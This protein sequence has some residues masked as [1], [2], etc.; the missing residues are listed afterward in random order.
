MDCVAVDSA[1]NVTVTGVDMNRDGTHECVST[2]PVDEPATMSST[3]PLTGNTIVATTAVVTT[4]FA[5]ADCTDSAI[6]T[7]SGD[8]CVTMSRGGGSFIPDGEYDSLWDNVK[9]MIA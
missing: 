5:S 7:C 8:I 1:C 4:C 2:A 9:P 6:P 3:I